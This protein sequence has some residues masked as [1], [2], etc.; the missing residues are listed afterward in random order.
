M[1]RIAY[2][3]GRYQPIGRATVSIEDRG[4]QFADG[5][6]E[7]I[8]VVD[9]R[10]RDLERHLERLARSLHE[11]GMAMPLTP[12]ALRLIVA[13]VL[14][15]NGLG[16]AAV[17]I[18]VDRGVAPRNHAFPKGAKPSLVVT[19]RR[20][21]W[22]KPA[23]IEHGV[24]VITLPDWRWARRD[25]KSIA[26]LPNVLARQKALEAGCREAWLIDAAGLVTEATSANAWIVL[27][28]GTIVTRPK[29]PEI[30]GGITRAVVLELARENGIEVV[31]RPFS[32]DEARRAPE[33]FI[34]G[35]G[36]LVLPV[37]TIDGRKVGDGRPGPTTLRLHDLYLAHCGL[38]HRLRAT[39]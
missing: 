16:A 35:T 12:A 14:A 29:G 10:P 17:Y 18:Q 37:T 15:L 3:N 19:A 25:I 9:G 31:E 32:L 4:L 26:L 7:M 6:Y 36:S 24:P 5:V 21:T 30:L 28:D 1:S 39:A 8:K 34:T 27:N 13:R 11:L 23:E 22:P 2:V 38:P 33:A 20:P